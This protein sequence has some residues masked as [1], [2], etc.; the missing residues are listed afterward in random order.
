MDVVVQYLVDQV[1]QFGPFVALLA[2]GAWD[3]RRQLI[4]C[5]EENKAVVREFLDHLM[6]AER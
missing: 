2:S 1:L 4:A 6:G 3:I 5:Q